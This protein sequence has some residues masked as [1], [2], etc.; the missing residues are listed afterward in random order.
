MHP[1]WSRTASLYQLNQRQL[2]P[3]GTFG[4][5]QR[6]L[7]RIR[8][9]GVGIIW[10]MPVH[11]IGKVN[12]KGALGS[13]YAVSDHKAVN[14]EFGDID[15]LRAFV[16]AAH[17]LGLKVILDWVANH[18]AWDHVLVEEHPEFFAR[19][20][21]GDFRP[22]PWW[23]WD[24][25][26][27]LDY[28]VPGVSDYMAEAMEFWVREC[29]VDGYRC[30]VAGF[31][32][33]V[34]WQDVRARLEA[35]KPVFMLAEWEQRDLHDGAFDASYAWTWN[36]TLHRVAAG[37]S[38]LSGLI[39]YY[40]QHQG[41]WPADA[42]RM[43]FVS[44]HDHNHADGTEYERFGDALP[45]ATV[46][47]VVGEGIPLIYSGQELGS[48]KRLAFF[49]KDLVEDTDTEQAELYRTLLALKRDNPALW[50]APWGAPMTRVVTDSP[51]EVLAFSRDVDGR[52]VLALFNLT[53][54]L[55]DVSLGAAVR[56]GDYTDLFTGVAVSV[57]AGWS[58]DLGPWG[59][60][61]LVR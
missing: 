42:M 10:L 57:A 3:E 26:I 31:V 56:G 21:E 45:I 23:D 12:R 59:C 54:S 13:P 52:G 48:R 60:R 44:N 46:L 61:V 11:P 27:D 51:D 18:T 40:A 5:A 15:D 2:T 50:N 22:T 6:Q 37:T 43:T 53:S 49:D 32:P 24:D 58:T 36:E 47:S 20:S 4:A 34:F 33:M 25:I 55:V 7:S 30:D 29:D 41:S 17:E 9:L 14:A 1:E 19:D 39:V 38:D 8:D 35:I 16:A 28:S